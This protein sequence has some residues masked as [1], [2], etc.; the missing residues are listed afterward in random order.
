LLYSTD[1]WTITTRGTRRITAAEIK[2]MRKTAA[3]TWTDY[4]TNIESVK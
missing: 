4:K 3:Y 2:F 1:N